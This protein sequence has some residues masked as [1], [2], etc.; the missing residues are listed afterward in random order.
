MLGKVAFLERNITVSVE[1]NA[2]ALG[3]VTHRS[4]LLVVRE[5]LTNLFSDFLI[6]I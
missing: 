3:S 5:A 2:K 4:F 6:I 1:I